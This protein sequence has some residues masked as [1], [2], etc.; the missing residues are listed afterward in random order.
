MTSTDLHPGCS[1]IREIRVIGAR[2]P[3]GN[4]GN[5]RRA[6]GRRS[7]D[8][9]IEAMRRRLET[10]ILPVVQSQTKPVNKWRRRY[11]TWLF[12]IKHKWLDLLFILIT[13]I[14]IITAVWILATSYPWTGGIRGEDYS[15]VVVTAATVTAFGG[16]L[17]SLVAAPLQ[18]ASQLAAGYSAELLQRGTLWI[19][20]AFL[21]VLAV[22]LFVLGALGPDKEAAVASGLL[23]GGGL[24]LVWM[25]ARLLLSSSDPQDVARRVARYIRRGMKDSRRFMRRMTKEALPKDLRDQPPGVLL[26]RTEERTIVNGFLRHFKAGVEGALAHRQP[27]SAIVLWDAALESF[28]D[29]AKEV[30]GDI[31]ESGGITET[32]LSIVD[33]LVQQGLAIPID[34]VA[35]H[36]IGSL[37]KLFSLKVESDSYSVVPSVALIKLRN[38]IQAGWADDN[39]R[40]SAAS[41]KAIGQLI[42]NGVRIEAHEE[43]LHGLTAL[44]EIATQAIADRRTHISKAA[45]E[46]VA[47]ALSSFLGAENERLRSYL[48][49]RWAHEARVLSQLRLAEGGVAFIRATESIFPG[50]TLWGK[51]I[52]EIIARLGPYAH[53]SAP[54][55]APLSEWLTR[56][57]SDFGAR[58]ENELH[59]YAI[60][61]F[62][63]LYC[64]SLTQAHAVAAGQPPRPEEATEMVTV[65][66]RWLDW[67]P[68]E[69]A[70][71]ALLTPDNAE[72]VWSVLLT[73]AYVANDPNML[74]ETAS[75]MLEKLGDRL[76]GP[77]V[78]DSFSVEFITGLL[79]AANRA[80]EEITAAWTQLVYRDSWGGSDRGMYIDGLGRVPSLNRNRVAIADPQVFE[81][82][83]VWAL[84]RFPRFAG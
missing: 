73:I 59:Y 77:P 38:W 35:V 8:P 83:N 22:G 64:L 69:D 17:F 53:L 36:P 51:G 84:E 12:Q 30:E 62:A 67:L 80:E 79:V 74:S 47:S 76:T 78:Y 32:L 45:L 50:I 49:K 65:V 72:L 71:N 9:M 56:A 15:G 6:L 63:V 34:D 46:E 43:A 57:V 27:V 25:S 20:G 41:L 82:V 55:V 75:S 39:T 21:V 48:I 60:E 44:Y 58:R 16:V 61:A 5:R 13:A 26:V 37:E 29:Y 2:Y 14:P 23:A 18:A 40:V 24:S 31:G 3:G 54:V 52:Q 42:E 28:L 68:E 19:T 70:G 1:R 10:D 4:G 66:Q 11:W 33:L 7:W 81:I